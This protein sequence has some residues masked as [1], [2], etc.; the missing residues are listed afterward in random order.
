MKRVAGLVPYT[1]DRLVIRWREPGTG[2]VLWQGKRVSGKCPID[3]EE[4]RVYV[5]GGPIRAIKIIMLRRNLG[6]RDAKSLL[7]QATKGRW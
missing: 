6:L 3:A 2:I 1:N 4:R 5:S 7:D